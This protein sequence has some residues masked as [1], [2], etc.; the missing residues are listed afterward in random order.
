[1][2]DDLLF[3]FHR[4]A[5]EVVAWS[6]AHR[7]WGLREDLR[8]LGTS[9]AAARPRAGQLPRDR[10]ALALDALADADDDLRR[11]F[12]AEARAVRPWAHLRR[13]WRL[14]ASAGVLR[15]KGHLWP[16]ATP[17]APRAG[18]AGRDL[19]A[20]VAAW[21]RELARQYHP[22]TGGSNKVMAALNHAA[23]RLKSV[24]GLG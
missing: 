5:A 18:Q 6:E 2:T 13:V 11:L 20:A 1:M 4:L 16:D 8:S 15:A 22:D 14:M 19:A 3:R 23:E 9:L 12:D 17:G 24:L 7:C 21:Y 10:L